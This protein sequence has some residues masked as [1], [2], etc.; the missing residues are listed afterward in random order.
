LPEAPTIVSDGG[1]PA[2]NV[3]IP[4][5]SLAVTDVN[6][7]DPDAGATLTYAIAGGADGGLFSIDAATG[8]VLWSTVQ[9]NVCPPG[10]KFCDPGISAA[11]TATPGAVFAG[12]LDGFVRAYDGVSGK[13]LWEHDTK[14]KIRTVNGLETSGG[15]MSGAGPAVAEGHLIINSGYGL[16]SHSPGNLLLVY[17]VDGK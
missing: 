11:I 10:L 2:A 15:S 9:K 14:A 5:N 8:K 3:N 17:S 13:L 4:E 1:G 7:I 6:A 12:H 16:Y